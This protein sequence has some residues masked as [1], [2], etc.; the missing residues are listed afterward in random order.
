MHD[1]AERPTTPTYEAALAYAALGWHVI[2]LKPRSKVAA[3]EWKKGQV[4]YQIHPPSHDELYMWFVEQTVQVRVAPG[5]DHW[6]EKHYDEPLGMAVILR[7]N[8]VGM[9]F[10]GLTLDEGGFRYWA[11]QYPLVR[12]LPRTRTGSGKVHV[13]FGVVHPMQGYNIQLPGGADAGVIEVRTGRNIDVL[14]PTIH[15]SGEPYHWEVP[16]PETGV[17]VIDPATVGVKARPKLEAVGPEYHEGD[18]L[19]EGEIDAIVEAVAPGWT[20]DYRH[21]LSLAV[22]GWLASIGAPEEDA[23]TVLTRLGAGEPHRQSEYQ[24]SVRDTYVLAAAG[25]RPK[26]WSLLR[27]T[28]DADALGVLEQI[29]KDHEPTFTMPPKDA[30]GVELPWSIGFGSFMQRTFPEPWWL[31]DNLMPGHQ[32]V[33]LRGPGGSMKSWF[34]MLAAVCVASGRDFLGHYVPEQRRVLYIQEE[35]AE[36]YLQE[37]GAALARML[38]IDPGSL[39]ETLRVVSGQSFK[40]DSNKENGWPRLLREIEEFA[41]SL[42]ILDPLVEMHDGEE[43]TV[44]SMRPVMLRLRQIRYAHPLTVLVLH[45]N[46]RLDQM[47]GSTSIKDAADL[48]I[49]IRPTDTLRKSLVH[50]EKAR[51]LR[52]PQDFIFE[53]RLVG[54]DDIDIARIDIGVAKARV[55]PPFTETT[56]MEYIEEYGE[57]NLPRIAEVHGMKQVNQKLRETIN[58]M[59]GRKMLKWWENKDGR[60]YSIEER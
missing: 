19:S 1:E 33:M 15:P 53:I 37:R 31:I 21:A 9:D 44:E 39:E 22:P 55:K 58:A 51:N 5:I 11:E 14:P 45:H 2:P 49:E 60:W 13:Y 7:D 57:L 32:V 3:I 30:A 26:G 54:E 18:S 56:I 43:N 28:L 27:D 48:V 38:G 35:M 52:D 20:P 12:T 8:L 46:N 34:A 47:R 6:R 50:F 4:N 24:R 59:A 25:I 17:P 40:I 23:R 42:I 29:A 41:P 16:I 10:D 36:V